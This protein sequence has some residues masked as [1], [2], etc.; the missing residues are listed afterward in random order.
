M[1]VMRDIHFGSTSDHGMAV[2]MEHDALPLWPDLP[3]FEAAMNVDG[4]DHTESECVTLG[5]FDSLELAMR[6]AT[7]AFT[8]HHFHCEAAV[9]HWVRG[10]EF[11]AAS[12]AR[13]TTDCRR[14]SNALIG[15]RSVA[16]IAA[17]LPLFV[18]I[19]FSVVGSTDALLSS[20]F[21]VVS[22]I[23]LEAIALVCWVWNYR[24]RHGVEHSA[25][26]W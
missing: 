11:D 4:A 1:N 19:L 15:T 10:E 18:V 8:L 23:A 17:A 24:L 3:C 14:L 5:L 21:F 25:I 2:V 22:S 13:A 6:A 7:A 9:Q 26:Y 20:P 16:R 12:T